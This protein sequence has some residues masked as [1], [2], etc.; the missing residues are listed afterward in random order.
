MKLRP[1]STKHSY[2]MEVTAEDLFL[3]PWRRPEA[4]AFGDCWLTMHAGQLFVQ[5]AETGAQ[6]IY[7]IRLRR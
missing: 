7:P 4:P 6:V 2:V 1:T 3:L 5:R